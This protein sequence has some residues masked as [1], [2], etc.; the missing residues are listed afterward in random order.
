MRPSEPTELY[1]ERN[2][3]YKPIIIK[4]TE[5]TMSKVK[6]ILQYWEQEE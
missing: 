3:R 6:T 5:K 1:K 4:L 2:K